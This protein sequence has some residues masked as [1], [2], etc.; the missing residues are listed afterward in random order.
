LKSVWADPIYSSVT[1]VLRYERIVMGKQ[2]LDK[3]PQIL[4]FATRSL[5]KSGSIAWFECERL[6]KDP[7]DPAPPRLIFYRV[8]HRSSR[9]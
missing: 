4:I 9:F 8:R 3:L 5:H 6:V 7:L 2:R 1:C